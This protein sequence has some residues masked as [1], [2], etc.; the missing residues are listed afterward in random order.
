MGDL[1]SNP[2]EPGGGAQSSRT[3]E[4]RDLSNLSRWATRLLYADAILCVVAIVSGV[5]EYQQLQSLRGIA[6]E[7][8]EAAVLEVVEGDR[9]G[10]I[11]LLQ[12]GVLIACAFV[13]LKWTYRANANV[14][15][16]GAKGMR[17]TPG[18]AVGWYFIP[19]LWL[20]KPYQA[21][22]EIWKA[23]SN[24]SD[25]GDASVPSLLP[26]W[27]FF[28]ICTGILG[29]ASLRISFRAKSLDQFL[30]LN[31]IDGLANLAEIP[32]ALILVVIVTR[33]TLMQETARKSSTK[34][35]LGAR[36]MP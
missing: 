33:A 34:A 14:R 12:L 5:L 27:W 36:H 35:G 22:K 15:A 1:T 28:W 32:A 6:Y 16:L 21:M 24:P 31:V 2:T 13:V 8:Q 30:G 26:W 4:Y 9:Q 10:V 7:S 3:Y 29:H 23:S 18:W 19:I 11:A 20:W 17:F 25:W